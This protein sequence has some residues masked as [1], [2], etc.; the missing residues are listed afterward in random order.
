MATT[1]TCLW[2]DTDGMAAARHYVSIFPSSSIDTVTYW[3]S[4]NPEREG[5][6][7]EVEFTLDGRRFVALNGGPGFPFTEAI[8][9]AVDCADQAEVDYY[10]DRL[11]DGGKADRCGWLADR[12]GLWW[13]VAPVRLRELMQQP[14][15]P[16]ARRVVD[17]MMQMVKIDIAELERAAEGR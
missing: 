5:Q 8:S 9:I 1:S 17:A 12:F 11:L 13:Q 7:L 3:G 14:D 2:F 15:K 10:W 4:E 6:V 16:R